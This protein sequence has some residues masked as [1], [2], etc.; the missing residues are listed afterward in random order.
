MPALNGSLITATPQ[1]QKAINRLGSELY[2]LADA[3]PSELDTESLNNWGSYYEC[4]PR[5]VAGNLSEAMTVLAS[6]K[7]YS[8]FISHYQDRIDTLA[9]MIKQ[10]RLS[11]TEHSFAA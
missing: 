7:I 4:Q 2:P 8:R 1:V 10:G 11:E 3:D 6:R 9:I 5:I